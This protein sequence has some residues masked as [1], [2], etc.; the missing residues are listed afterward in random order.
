MKGLK[1]C[2]NGHWYNESEKC[3][4]C[5][6]NIEA[7]NNR[8]EYIR[9]IWNLKLVE[10]S[11]KPIGQKQEKLRHKAIKNQ[12]IKFKVDEV[13][14]KK[15]LLQP[16][17]YK[18]IIADL[19]EKANNYKKC[20]YN[21][22]IVVYNDDCEQLL[23]YG[24]NAFLKGLMMAYGKHYPIILYPDIIWEIISLGF[25]QH[26]N[27]NAEKLRHF[28]VDFKG[29]ARIQLITRYHYS[30]KNLDWI[31]LFDIFN[32]EIASHIGKDLIDNLT[33][34]FTTTTSTTKIASQISIM[35]AFK[36]YFDYS[37]VTLCGFP[38]ITLEGT[39]DDWKNILFK[40]QTLAKYELEWWIDCLV[41]I[42]QEFVNASSGNVN[43]DFWKKMCNLY[44]TK[45]SG[46][47]TYLQGWLVYFFPY[48]IHG[49]T[50][51]G[52]FSLWQSKSKR[53]CVD[54][55]D[56]P[57][58]ITACDLIWTDLVTGVDTGLEINAGIVGLEQN[59]ETFAIKPVVGWWVN[60]K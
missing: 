39:P 60:E 32:V 22:K 46:A 59:P 53:I 21:S 16:E 5:R 6:I 4:Y 34:N 58:E 3:P 50:R 19:L 55:N 25:A 36:T 54:I 11:I 28:F 27:N 17:N 12:Q 26:V 18:N 15:E 24:N 14:R 47:T 44:H 42:L 35:N 10:N 48:G 37:S 13:E 8:E 43:T 31:E 20:D 56:F 40:T 33:A 57:S 1:K 9:D 41:P 2:P 30:D 49:N 7:D 52:E 23:P 29:K 45:G 38:E 51:A